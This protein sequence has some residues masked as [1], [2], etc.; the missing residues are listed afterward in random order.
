MI[1][2]RSSGEC[3]GRSLRSVCYFSLVIV[4]SLIGSRGTTAAISRGSFFVE[5]YGG[6]L[7]Q[8]VGVFQLT[9]MNMSRQSKLYK[10][11]FMFYQ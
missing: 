10:R 7:G 6:G 1:T 2:Y 5:D 11:S 8:A 9:M 3:R 4:T